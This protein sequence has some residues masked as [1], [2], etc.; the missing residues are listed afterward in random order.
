MLFKG[1]LLRYVASVSL[2]NSSYVIKKKKKKIRCPLIHMNSSKGKKTS[3]YKRYTYLNKNCIF[4][5]TTHIWT[6]FF[7][8][9]IP[10][11]SI[12]LLLLMT[13]Y[14]LIRMKNN[15]AAERYYA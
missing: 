9:Y 10:E 2:D 7:Y 1:Y 11:S 14:S 3:I 12:S 4:S 5:V 8:R 6:A 13:L 15:D